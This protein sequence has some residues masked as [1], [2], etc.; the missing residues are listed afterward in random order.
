MFQ[1]VN[2]MSSLAKELGVEIETNASV[3]KINED[4]GKVVGIETSKG[5]YKSDAV[6]A[7][8]DYAHVD[9]KLLPK[10]KQNYSSEYW[11]KKTFAPSCL[12]F[13]IGVKK[14]IGKLIHHNLFFDTDFDVHA[15]EIYKTPKWPTDPLFYVC[16]PSKTDKTVAPIGHENLFIL[17]PIATG[18][19]DNEELREKYF[20]IVISRLEKYVG[21]DITPFMDYK[22][23]YCIH[24]FIKDYNS[25]GG[26]AYGL[27]NTLLQT[28]V[29][30]PKMINKK[31]KNLIY[32]GQLTV[33]GPGV[34]PSLISG[35]IAAQLLNN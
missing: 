30:K 23:S 24:N 6:I 12:L 19:E 10:N 26:N 16:C 32:T 5:Y 17:I 22:K 11:K 27:A 29:L 2:A 21:E 18:L 15:N 35:K 28:A 31:I 7:S 1:I 13:Y 33:P 9:Q 20:N 25:Y 8:A 34:P 3:T 14:E 4:G